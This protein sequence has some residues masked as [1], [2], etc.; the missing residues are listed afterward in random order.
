[1]ITDY[2]AGNSHTYSKRPD[3]WDKEKI[4]EAEFKLPFVDKVVYRVI[5][6]E[7]DPRDRAAHRQARHHGV[8]QLGEHGYAE[9]VRHRI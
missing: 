5:R 1:M 2:V 6:D 3:Y 7:L 8:C 9:E 4:D